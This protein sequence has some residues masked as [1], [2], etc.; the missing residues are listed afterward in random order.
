MNIKRFIFPTFFLLFFSFWLAL[1]INVVLRLVSN[2]QVPLSSASPFEAFFGLLYWL[3]AILAAATSFSFGMEKLGLLSDLRNIIQGKEKEKGFEPEV[4]M[5]MLDSQPSSFPTKAAGEGNLLLEQTNITEVITKI[6]E[7]EKQTEE[8]IE[9]DKLKAYYLFGE[10]EF[11][12]CQ[13]KFG[14]L[15][16]DENKPIPDECF[17]CSKVIECFNYFKKPN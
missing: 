9:K 13:H 3:V 17:G 14:F 12:G 10:T 16:I 7:P 6:N 11:K 15:A 5:A 2:P 1:V 8:P 4:F